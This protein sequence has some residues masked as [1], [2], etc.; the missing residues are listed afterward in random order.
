VKR[1]QALVFGL[2]DRLAGVR[3]PS[4]LVGL[5]ETVGDTVVL[6]ETLNLADAASIVW[7]LRGIGGSGIRTL[8]VPTEAV[9]LPDRSFAVRATV[10]FAELIGK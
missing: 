7:N 2:L 10:T 1:Q 3:S 6:D 5:A 4:E 8:T 9:V